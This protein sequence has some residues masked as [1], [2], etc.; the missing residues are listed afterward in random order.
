[1]ALV[2]LALAAWVYRR[3]ETTRRLANRAALALLPW[4]RRAVV[5]VVILLGG[6]ETVFR[7]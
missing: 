4:V 6:Q 2:W 7:F 5:L 3:D 1:M